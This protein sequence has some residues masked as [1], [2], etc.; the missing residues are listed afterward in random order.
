MPPKRYMVRPGPRPS[1]VDG[2]NPGASDRAADGSGEGW[3]GHGGGAAREDAAHP[4]RHIASGTCA[5]PTPAPAPAAA[6]ARAAAAAAAAASAATPAATAPRRRRDATRAEAAAKAAPPHASLLHFKHL[7][8]HLADNEYIRA[9]YRPVAPSRRAALASLF[10]LHNESGNV[11]SHLLG[12]LLFAVLAAT[13]HARAPAPLDAARLHGLIAA[14]GGGL[15]AGAVRAEH[16]A[17]AA[18]AG[19]AARLAAA[20]RAGGHHHAARPGHPPASALPS[21]L[22]PSPSPAPPPPRP[23]PALAAALKSVEHALASRRTGAAAAGP[24]AA[25]AAAAGA[26]A[27][28][29]AAAGLARELAALEA[30]LARAARAVRAGAKAEVASLEAAASRAARH[31]LGAAWPAPRWPVLVFFAG[32]MACLGA[33]ATCHL[34]A[35]LPAPVATAIWRFDYAGIVALI[36]AR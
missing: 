3:A 7:P 36:V 4:P 2:P 1:L 35:C 22:P 8:P 26:S 14:G 31:A 20:L 25:A 32:A 29:R 24:P 33:S 21:P 6:A 9:F 13:L 17:A 23:S 12:F 34:L 16:A 28:R 19:A 5:A 15:A 27:A 10:R 18:L 30:A 11:W